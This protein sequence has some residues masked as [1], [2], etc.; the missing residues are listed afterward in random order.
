[1][2]ES[3]LPASLLERF[4]QRPNADSVNSPE[5]DQF[6]GLCADELLDHPGDL[7]GWSNCVSPPDCTQ[8]Y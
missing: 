7:K 2:E 4:A 5:R 1:V 8:D 3:L 6:C